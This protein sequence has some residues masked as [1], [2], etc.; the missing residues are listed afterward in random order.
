MKI[1]KL[2]AAMLILAVTL[3]SFVSCEEKKTAAELEVSAAAYMLTNPYVVKM[4]YDLNSDNEDINDTFELLDMDTEI[5]MDGKNF[6]V[7]TGLV[8]QTMTVLY[9][10]GMMYM[11]A[12]GAK[13]KV[14][15]SEEDYAKVAEEM[16]GEAEMIFTSS[17]FDDVEVVKSSDGTYTVK[18]NEVSDGALDKVNEFAA[19]YNDMGSFSIDSLRYEMVYDKDGR[20]T[21]AEIGFEMAVDM[22]GV[23][24]A[25]SVKSVA[26]YAYEGAKNITAPADADQYTEMDFGDIMGSN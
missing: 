4:S 21:V 2:L 18:C 15:V 20:A 8:G 3:I 24:A 25:V 26:T 1:K 13:I 5:A 23:S 9:A 17:D 7:S 14:A 22:D 11:D 6:K 16:I 10:D 12:A 19:S